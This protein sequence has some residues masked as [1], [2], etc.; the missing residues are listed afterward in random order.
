MTHTANFDGACEPINP[1][2]WGGWGFAI[3]DG[4]GAEVLARGGVLERSAA[5][6]NNVAEYTA[7]LE[8]VRAWLELG[9]DGPILVRGDSKLVIEQMSGRWKAK[10][11]AYLAVYRELRELVDRTAVRVTWAWVPRTENARADELS[12]QELVRRGVRIAH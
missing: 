2:G 10:Q 5:M 4:A 12:K 11:G 7:A 8:C 3:V 1:G 9:I 6:T